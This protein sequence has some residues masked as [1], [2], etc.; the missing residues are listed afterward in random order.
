MLFDIFEILSFEDTVQAGLDNRA[1]LTAKAS[2][3]NGACPNFVV[4]PSRNPFAVSV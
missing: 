1:V 2:F 3:G 4:C